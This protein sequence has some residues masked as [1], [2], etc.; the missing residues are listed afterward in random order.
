M[1]RNAMKC[2]VCKNHGPYTDINLHSNGFAEEITTCSVCGTI[3]SVNHGLMEI[4][5]DPQENSFLA[6]ASE[7]VEADD[8]NYAA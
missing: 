8:Y 3:W 4:I 2:P 7:C 1:K 6:V 5:K